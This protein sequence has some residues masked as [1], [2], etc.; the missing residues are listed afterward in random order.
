MIKQFVSLIASIPVA[1]ISSAPIVLGTQVF[2]ASSVYAA[3]VGTCAKL[4]Q[5]CLEGPETRTI[6]GKQITKQCWKYEDVYACN[7]QTVQNSCA[8]LQGRSGYQQ[9]KS[10]CTNEKYSYCDNYTKEYTGTI[11]PG[12]PL[13]SPLPTGVTLLSDQKVISRDVIQTTCGSLDNNGDCSQIGAKVCVEGRETRTINGLAVTKDCWKWEKTY[14]CVGTIKTDCTNIEKRAG[15]RLTAT[16]VISRDDAGN[17][18]FTEKVFTCTSTVDRYAPD[19]KVCQNGKANIWGNDYTITRGKNGDFAKAVTWGNLLQRAS[20]DKDVN[21]VSIFTGQNKT[22][23]KAIGGLSNCCRNDGFLVDQDLVGCSA[24]ETELAK[25]QAKGR[26]KYIGTFCSKKVFKVCIKKKK[27]FCVFK[28][29]LARILHEQ[30]RPQIGLSWGGA[31]SPTCRGFTVQE[32]QR[33]DFSQIDLS[34]FYNDAIAK[35]NNIL[36][37]NTK[38]KLKERIDNYYQKKGAK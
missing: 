33:L 19:K 11:P 7:R 15:C 24:E 5:R 1:F 36:N 10:T 23:S 18:T 26:A 12:V 32:L 21:G 13:A 8:V 27:S 4:G 29:K 25:Q 34:E 16:N 14:K 17:P 9:S 28:S 22:C 3:P 37:K 38:T 31:K 6:L 2:T 35:Q 30:G 20:K